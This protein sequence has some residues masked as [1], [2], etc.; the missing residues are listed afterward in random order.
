MI[1]V[2]VN[3]P[4]LEPQRLKIQFFQGKCYSGL[5]TVSVINLT[6]AKHIPN[7]SVLECILPS[8]NGGFIYGILYLV[9]KTSVS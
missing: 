9:V 3:T 5:L 7:Y 8:S 6:A 4:K 1:I 2:K